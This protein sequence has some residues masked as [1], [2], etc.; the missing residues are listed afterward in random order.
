MRRSLHR[1]AEPYPV[2]HSLT[3]LDSGRAARN[4][5]GIAAGNVSRLPH[6]NVAAH[7]CDQP[8]LT[9]EALW[10]ALRIV[11]SLSTIL[12]QSTQSIYWC[13]FSYTRSESLVAEAAR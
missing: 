8:P 10:L 5:P 7:S 9:S 4:G 1:S 3:A 2:R 13:A 11:D 6:A 12:S